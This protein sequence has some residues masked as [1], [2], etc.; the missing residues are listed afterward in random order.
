[1]PFDTTF[2]TTQSAT[3]RNSGKLSARKTAYVSLVCN[4]Q[5]HVETGVGGLWLRRS[6]VRSPSLT[7]I[8]Y[9]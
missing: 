4:I 8:G 6:R 5:Q 2:D 3:R 9:R 1:M 7:L